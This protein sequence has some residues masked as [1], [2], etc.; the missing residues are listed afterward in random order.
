ME[1]A[2]PKDGNST[3]PD[4]YYFLRRSQDVRWR[5]S[6]LCLRPH[7]RKASVHMNM[8]WRNEAVPPFSS[9]QG[10]TI[11]VE[12]ARQMIRNTVNA[13]WGCICLHETHVF[14]KSYMYIE[15]QISIIMSKQDYINFLILFK[16]QSF[17]QLHLLWFWT[18]SC[19]IE[20]S[21]NF[22]VPTG[23]L[24]VGTT[25]LSLQFPQQQGVSSH[26]R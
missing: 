6:E 24:S 18:V 4:G 13:T 16:Y 19:T 25:P 7:K 15:S 17:R 21:S 8:S 10:F 3:D 1:P 23:A 26:T 14:L 5:W 20:L 22:P 2:L 12:F 11:R 9:V